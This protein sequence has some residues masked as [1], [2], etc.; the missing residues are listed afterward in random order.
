MGTTTHGIEYPDSTDHT[1]IWEHL[2]TLA[3]DADALAVPIFA[4]NT[5]RD[6]AIPAPSEGR[7]AFVTGTDE[8]LVYRAAWVSAS[9]RTV[10]KTAAE[11]VVSSTSL[12][13][14][15][16]LVLP[17]EANSKYAVEGLFIVAANSATPDIKFSFSLP[18]SATLSWTLSGNDNTAGT[19]DYAAIVDMASNGST[20][21]RPTNGSIPFGYQMAGYLATGA[22]AGN[23]RLRWAQVAS[24]AAAS[25]L[26]A[27]SWLRIL[28]VA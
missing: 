22:N 11:D 26:A 9:P 24:N 12:Q 3:D 21:E 7:R 5:T 23:L 19:A 2:Q 15:D 14:D 8:D 17:I 6:A 18:T 20:K 4:T 25:R 10:Y 16:H 28:K 1:R 27:G 13:D